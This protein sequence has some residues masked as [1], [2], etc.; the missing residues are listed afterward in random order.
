MNKTILISLTLFNLLGF[1]QFA[2]SASHYNNNY[3]NDRRGDHRNDYND[4]RCVA[5]DKGYE[6]HWGGHETCAKCLVKHGKCV[7]SC[8]DEET[9]C[10]A[11]GIRNGYTRKFPVSGKNR[12]R[13]EENA[14]RECELSGYEDC[15]LINCQSEDRLVSRR[16][17]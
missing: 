17:C 8:Y 13:T 12:W 14:V 9:L 7:E 1:S 15:R 2:N 16:R 11:E 6:E 5:N 10:T 3:R 4:L